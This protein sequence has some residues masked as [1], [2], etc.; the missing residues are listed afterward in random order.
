MKLR[1]KDGLARFFVH[2][3]DVGHPIEIDQNR[4]LSPKQQRKI[5]CRPELLHLF[6]VEIARRWQHRSTSGRWPR[7]TA[8]VICSLNFRPYQYMVNSKF[9]LAS[10]PPWR[11]HN[12]W[13]HELVPLGT[14]DHPYV[15]FVLFLCFCV[16]VLFCFLQI[17]ADA[18]FQADC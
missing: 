18:I 15:F 11:W 6:A 10:L 4:L 16:F 7:V 12:V 9:D 14:I 17:F 3:D 1:D 13:V 8:E 2:D 5:S